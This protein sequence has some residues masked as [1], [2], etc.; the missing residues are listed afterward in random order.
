M[1]ELRAEAVNLIEKMPEEYLFAIVQ[2][3]QDFLK[4]KEYAEHQVR[5][6]LWQQDPDK[7]EDEINEYVNRWVKETRNEERVKKNANFN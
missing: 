2:Y 7:Y 1:S 5:V 3:A 4:D 6:A